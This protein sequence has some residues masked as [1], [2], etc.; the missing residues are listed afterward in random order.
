MTRTK[1]PSKRKPTPRPKQIDPLDAEFKAMQKELGFT[2]GAEEYEADLNAKIY[3]TGCLGLDCLLGRGGMAERTVIELFGDPGAGKS[4]TLMHMIKAH[5]EAGKLA[6]VVYSEQNFMK[7]AKDIGVDIDR[8]MIFN[9]FDPKRNKKDNGILAE[10]ALR[11]AA[12]ACLNPRVGF[13]G[14]DSV[15]GLVSATQVY[16]KGDMRRKKE[17]SFS[18]SE[19]APRANLMEKFFNRLKSRDNASIVMLNHSSTPIN[20]G[21]FAPSMRSNAT[22][23]GGRKEFEAIYRIHV[24]NSALEGEGEHKLFG[25]KDSPGLKIRYRLV[26]SRW[27]GRGRKISAE[28]RYATNSFDLSAEVLKYGV[29]LGLIQK[30]GNYYYFD[31]KKSKFAGSTAKAHAF[32]DEHPDYVQFL[33]QE[34]LLRSEELLSVKA[35]E[36]S[37][38][39]SIEIPMEEDEEDDDLDD[40]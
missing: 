36:K 38:G 20:M 29:Y 14:I 10:D 16:E 12:R 13:L 23:G 8:L 34:I 31:E 3:S 2:T 35:D 22:S 37:R 5:Q 7:F 39:K 15:K 40:D 11:D 9:A 33:K 17:R 19:T 27:G 30:A 4:I 1:A 32:L 21:M 6:A 18:A 28:Y 24:A 26:K 25:Y